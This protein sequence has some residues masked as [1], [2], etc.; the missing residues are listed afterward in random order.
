MVSHQLL[1]L[2][3]EWDC[4][5]PA[6]PTAPHRERPGSRV[7][8][9]GPVV[10]NIPWCVLVDPKCVHLKRMGSWLL[11]IIMDG[12]NPYRNPI[13][14]T[15]FNHHWLIRVRPFVRLMVVKNARTTKMWPWV[16]SQRMMT[17]VPTT[18]RWDPPLGITWRTS[19]SV[20]KGSDL[21]NASPRARK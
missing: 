19:A 11:T 2:P 15:M 8:A 18:G 20:K 16:I 1:S 17:R 12:I 6:R 4:P 21:G 13:F 3:L 9:W 5:G 10:P 14:L 7:A